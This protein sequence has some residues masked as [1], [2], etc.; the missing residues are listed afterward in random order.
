[1]LKLDLTI[2][3]ML[4]ILETEAVGVPARTLKRKVNLCM[5]SRESAKGVVFWPI[6]GARFDAHQFVSQMEKDGALMSVVN[7]TAIDPNFKMYA[8]VEDTTKALLKLAKGY[9]RLFKLKKVAITGSNG[10]TTTKEMTKAVLSMKFNT[11]ATKGNF[12]NHIGV[13]MTLFQLKHSHEAAVVEMGTSGP[14]EIRPLSLATEPDIAVITNIGASHLERLGDLDGVFNEKINIVAGLKKGGT[15]IVN[16]DDERLCK[17]KATKNYKVVT[18]GVRRGVVKPE[19]LK[20]TENLCA[21]FY[22][23]RTHFVLNVPGDHNLYDALAAIAVGEALRI[24]KGD[25]AKALAGFTSTSMRME[26]KVANGFKVISDCYNAN[27]SSTKMALQTL[28]NM[29]VAGL[30]I[31]VLGD[32]LEL[33][34]ESGNLHKQIGAMVPEMNFDL[35]LAVGKEAKK[36][37]EGAKSRG[38]KNVFHFDSVDEAV[39]HLSQTVAE[40][41]V[42]LVK[43]S[44]GMHMEKVVDALLSMVPVIR[45]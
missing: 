13:P 45:F 19:K 41:D 23:G 31:A 34:K 33:G 42:V 40:G 16:A 17:V 18:F 22:I 12:N 39:N 32:M 25:I 29:K 15:L 11:H 9:Q 21:D 8:P 38:M 3:E 43:G 6:K 24:P 26:I 20:W 28:G 35:L 14:D 1:M 10:K 36:Y 7:Q 4:K 5:D 30:R 2:A 37:V 44:R 27:P